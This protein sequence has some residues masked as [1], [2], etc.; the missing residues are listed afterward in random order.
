MKMRSWRFHEAGHISNLKMEE[1]DIPEPDQDEALVRV[2]YA[3]LN[4]ADKFLV[5][6]RYP[7]AGT[8]PFAVGRD[9]CGIVEEPGNSGRF[10]TG[11]RVVV[12]RSNIGIT[13][14]GT[15]ADYVTVPET[16]LA[17]IPDWWEPRDGAAGPL[18]LLT[19]WQALSIAARVREEER[20]VITGASGG[21]GTSA[22]I[23]AKAMGA[24]TIALSRS[25]DKRRKLVDLGADEAF[26]TN[27]E[28]L[29]K[30]I[31]AA[32]GADVVIENI[33]GEFLA[34]SVDMANLYGRICI[35]GGLGGIKS[36][37]NTMKI[38]FKRLQ[39]HGIQVG[40]YSDE[41]VQEA[42]KRIIR[43]L[44][45]VEAKVPIDRT[46]AFDEVQEAFEH[47]RLG[48]LGKVVI[49]PMN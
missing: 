45:T 46:Y 7:G 36:E 33:C 37:I 39:I 48:P 5:M 11:D 42:W 49:G 1:V 3:G 40:D 38:L 43:A 34:K 30:K 22:I 14:E 28:E 23:L 27:D 29:V 19:N 32:G 18:V 16:C 24:R 17:N 20:V 26:D 44:K 4:P 47:M 10:T 31:S 13:R 35:I 15:L 41:G 25:D 12:L 6:G 9:G 2:E 8:P 21:I